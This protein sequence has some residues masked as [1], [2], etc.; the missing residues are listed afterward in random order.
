MLTNFL[1]WG[2]EGHLLT[3]QEFTDKNALTLIEAGRVVI[4]GWKYRVIIDKDNI[5]AKS[6]G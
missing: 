2:I 6:R 5:S 4:Q 3:K 1:Y